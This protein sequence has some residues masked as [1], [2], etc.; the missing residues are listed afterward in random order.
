MGNI[1]RHA[2][3]STKDNILHQ[4]VKKLKENRKENR[5]TVKTNAYTARIRLGKDQYR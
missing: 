5:E 2:F 1:D 3:S 4:S